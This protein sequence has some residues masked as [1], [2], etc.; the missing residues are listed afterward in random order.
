MKEHIHHNLPWRS[1]P[2]PSQKRQKRPARLKTPAEEPFLSSYHSHD[3]D[4]QN[5]LCALGAVLYVSLDHT[6]FPTHNSQCSAKGRVKSC[7]V[8]KGTGI[9]DRVL[10]LSTGLPAA[11]P[12]PLSLLSLHTTLY[13]R[14]S[15]EAAVKRI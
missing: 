15:Q 14:Y 1:S 7:P 4:T 8:P 12:G 13:R 10:A 5:Y 6:L 9:T 3:L 2:G 11:C